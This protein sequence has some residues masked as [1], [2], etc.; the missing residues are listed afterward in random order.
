MTPSRA[1]RWACRRLWVGMSLAA[2]MVAQS[3]PVLAAT[4]SFDEVRAAWRSSETVLLDRHGVPVQAMRTDMQARRGDW[5]PL[6]GVSP[7]LR[8]AVI[9]SEDRRFLAHAGVDWKAVTGAAIGRADAGGTR[10]A[11]TIT[12]QL[13][14]LLDADLALPRGGRS[15]VAKVEQAAAA[16]RLERRWSKEQILEAWLN[17]VPFR[18]EQ[19]GVD[20][21]SRGLCQTSA[22]GLDAEEAAIAAALLR[23]PNA[24]PAVVGQRA[25]GVLRAQGRA[26]L[27]ATAQGFAEMILPREGQGRSGMANGL[28]LPS[29]EQLAPHFARQ[30]LSAYASNGGARGDARPSA[31]ASLRTTLDAGT[32]RFARDALRQQLAELRDRDV[33]DGAVIVL[34]NATGDVLAWVGSSGDLSQAAEVDA[35]VAP[36]QAGSTLKPFLYEQAIEQRWLTAAS[37]LDDSPA[38]LHTP[39]GLYIPQDYDHDFKGRVSVRTA[40]G[41][42]LNVPA[43]RTV[44]M[45]S[46]DRF[47]RRLVALGLPIRKPGGFYG[48]GIALGAPEVTLLTLANAYRTLANGG[49]ASAPRLRLA[50][51]GE[52]L[53]ATAPGMRR[54]GV[55]A[56]WVERGKDASAIRVADASAIR[57]MD[58]SASWIVAD[59]LSDNG[60]RV[61]TFG[62][63]NALATRYWSAVK[64]GTSKD[65]RDNW[66]LGFSARYTV[67]V[68]V[69]NASGAPMHAVSGVT[70]AAPVWRRVMDALQRSDAPVQ[71]PGRL[72]QA[73]ATTVS[74]QADRAPAP[75][76]IVARPISF[77][78]E[79]EAARTEWFVAGTE[80]SRVVLA[81]AAG[82]AARLI[83][84]PD[85]RSVVAIDPDI[86]PAVQRLRFE[87]VE[88]LPAGAAW[89]LDG[90]RLG[91]ATPLPWSPWPGHHQLELVD[92]RGGVLDAVTFDV[93]GAQA[94]RHPDA[95]RRDAL[96]SSARPSVVLS[97]PRHATI[98]VPS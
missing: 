77:A 50:A 17:L 47:A 90:K 28:S 9:A 62:L 5:V 66:C 80:T 10:G 39:S 44:V 61:P 69:G 11:S 22:A 60:A 64:T 83:A 26:D 81:S 24:A 58:A 51:P 20:A 87:A 88:P 68:W 71:H 56:P 13:A 8:A 57:V 67:G 32:Q 73:N 4:P 79:L 30:V 95:Q 41:S 89:R 38:R 75:R 7:A 63:D 93:R 96:P 14:G 54:G 12:M 85:D 25:C 70:G 21:L 45:V 43:V 94:S 84:S 98:D 37:V 40:L 92:A 46:P 52:M 1:P 29:G 91:R 74:A 55:S 78:N 72:S 86:P 36:R 27:C 82:T 3:L 97:P 48:Y 49:M 15:V 6:A 33:E 53:P 31:P 23:A 18:G 42:S 2:S 16:M 35:V 59:I 76:G 19:V 65:M 34:D